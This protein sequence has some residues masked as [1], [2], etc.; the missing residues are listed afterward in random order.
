MQIIRALGELGYSDRELA[1]DFIIGGVF[2]IKIACCGYEAHQG[3]ILIGIESRLQIEA[4]FPI[5]FSLSDDGGIKGVLLLGCG[6][7]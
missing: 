6:I 4:V 1:L 2:Q 7:S 5:F 3:V